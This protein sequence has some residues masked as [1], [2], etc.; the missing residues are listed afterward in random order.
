MLELRSKDGRIVYNIKLFC[1]NDN[2]IGGVVGGAIG[3][4]IGT[5]LGSKTEGKSVA[6]TLSET[7]FRQNYEYLCNRLK[8][9]EKEQANS[10]KLFNFL[11][12]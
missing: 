6:E 2:V 10:F 11:N 7:D 5:F 8:L 1:Y 3:T 4:V 12:D 9:D